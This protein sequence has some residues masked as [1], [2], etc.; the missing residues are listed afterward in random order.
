MMHGQ[1]NIKLYYEV[2]MK[3]VCTYKLSLKSD[4]NRCFSSRPA[5]ERNLL[6]IYWRKNTANECKNN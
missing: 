5:H 2:L 4:V 1:K 3:L 6:N